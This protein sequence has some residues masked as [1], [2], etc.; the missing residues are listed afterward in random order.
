M[1]YGR[2]TLE[3]LRL[4]EE[5]GV[6]FPEA[7]AEAE[8]DELEVLNTHVSCAREARRWVRYL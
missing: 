4:A 1:T 7:V 6:V 2:S 8:V 3:D 5:A